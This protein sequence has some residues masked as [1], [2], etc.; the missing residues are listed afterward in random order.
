MLLLA[1]VAAWAHTYSQTVLIT[2]IAYWRYGDSNVE[3]ARNTGEIQII[4]G[5]YDKLHMA[6]GWRD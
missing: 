4:G 5:C 2:V 1:V 3:R 6:N